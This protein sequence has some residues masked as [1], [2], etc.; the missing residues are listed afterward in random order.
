MFLRSRTTSR[1]LVDALH[2]ERVEPQHLLDVLGRELALLRVVAR[3][4]ADV[5]GRG[6][7]AFGVTQV[8]ARRQRV[9]LVQRAVQAQSFLDQLEALRLE[10]RSQ[11]RLIVGRSEQRVLG[12]RGGSH[13]RGR[14][15]STGEPGAVSFC[16]CSG[17]TLLIN[18]VARGINSLEALELVL[19]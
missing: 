16:W 1:L 3:H 13:P 6:L 14:V 4:L 5:A 11:P 9:H 10:V 12:R 17:S 7:E 2:V 18:R 8:Q 19:S 15:F